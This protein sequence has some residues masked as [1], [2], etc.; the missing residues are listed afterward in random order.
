MSLHHLA[1][2]SQ[3][4]KCTLPGY[5]NSGSFQQT[6]VGEERL[7]DEPKEC[8]RGR[9]LSPRNAQKEKNDRGEKNKIKVKSNPVFLSK[10]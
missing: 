3:G 1:G 5:V 9:L 4:I 2:I 7:R 6:F 10:F 8:L